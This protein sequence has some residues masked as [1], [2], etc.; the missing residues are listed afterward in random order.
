MGGCRV[1]EARRGGGGGEAEAARW[2]GFGGVE[3][4]VEVEAVVGG[5]ES[6]CRHWSGR[7]SLSSPL[8]SPCLIASSRGDWIVKYIFRGT[9]LEMS[10]S[11][12]SVVK[13][14]NLGR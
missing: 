5:W 10:H 4:E 12:I 8:S 11:G 6:G 9:L 13:G 7:W 14:I 2:G 3:V 1:L